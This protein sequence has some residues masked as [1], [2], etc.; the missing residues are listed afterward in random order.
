MNKKD[1]LP[2]LRIVT[3]DYKPKLGENII[4][5]YIGGLILIRMVSKSITQE[6]FSK[7]C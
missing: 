3:F 6:D 5:G 7:M 1:K 2:D 4:K